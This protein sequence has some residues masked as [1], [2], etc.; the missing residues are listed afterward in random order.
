MQHPVHLRVGPLPGQ[1]TVHEVLSFS[2]DPKHRWEVDEYIDGS[3]VGVQIR[4]FSRSS[5]PNWPNAMV[6]YAA[7]VD[8][9]ADPTEPDIGAL[10]EQG[11]LRFIS[12]LDE[13]IAGDGSADKKNHLTVQ[14]MDGSHVL[15]STYLLYRKGAPLRIHMRRFT[16]ANRRWVF[17]TEA[18]AEDHESQCLLADIRKPFLRERRLSGAVT[19]PRAR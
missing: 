19:Q 18:H 13:A 12:V 8:G 16:Q 2:L 11:L 10:D 7:I 4:A 14:L 9:S 6:G 17:L 15:L 1:W 3:G 5:D